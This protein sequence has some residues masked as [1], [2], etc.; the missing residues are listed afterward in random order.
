MDSNLN[1]CREFSIRR[2]CY[3]WKALFLEC[4]PSFFSGFGH[5]TPGE[6]HGQKNTVILS[7]QAYPDDLVET[8]TCRSELN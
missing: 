3:S 6:F 4:F 5:R 1:S 2:K 7:G 8:S